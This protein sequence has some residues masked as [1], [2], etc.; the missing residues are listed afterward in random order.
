MARA[1]S[2]YRSSQEPTAKTVS[3][4]PARAAAA[5][6]AWS[7]AGSPEPWKVKATSGEA[8]PATN[9]AGWTGAGPGGGGAG[10]GA[11]V[12]GVPMVS[13]LRLRAQTVSA[14]EEA[15]ARKV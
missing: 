3:G 1:A 7:R 14:S 8:P 4:A 5:R 6:R 2:G 15:A 11:P 13:P 12:V 10:E 9:R